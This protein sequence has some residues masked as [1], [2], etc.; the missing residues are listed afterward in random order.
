[1]LNK[2]YT[3]IRFTWKTQN[4]RHLGSIRTCCVYRMGVIKDLL[5]LSDVVMAQK[6]RDEALDAAAAE[7]ER[8]IRAAAARAQAAA[9]AVH[10]RA[11]ELGKRRMQ[12][13]A[14]E[15]RERNAKLK[16]FKQG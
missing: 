5:R 8:M 12:A 16:R 15:L 3:N 13:M 2:H 7:H 4:W 11:I 9:A 10:K 6:E 1:M 14:N